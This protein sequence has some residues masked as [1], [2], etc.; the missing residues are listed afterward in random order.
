MNQQPFD[1]SVSSLQNYQTPDW[2]RDA[3]FGIWSHWGPNAVARQGDWY[4]RRMYMQG[5]AQYEHHLKNYGHPSVHGYKDLIPLWKAENWDPDSLME[6]YVK[7]GA[8]YFVSMASFHDNFDLWNSKFH[9]WNAVN[10]G[11]QRDIVGDWRANG[12]RR[13]RL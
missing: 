4:A 11:P 6:L 5:E 7:A 2:F 3:K 13:A 1:A 9:R 12:N 10:M 8:K